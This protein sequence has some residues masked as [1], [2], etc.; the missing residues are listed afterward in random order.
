MPFMPP[1]WMT[2]LKRDLVFSHPGQAHP[3]QPLHAFHG[4]TKHMHGI[5]MHTSFSTGAGHSSEDLRDLPITR[6]R[7]RDPLV[8][9]FF[10]EQAVHEFHAPTVAV[11]GHL[12]RLQTWLR[13]VSLGGGLPPQ[14][15]ATRTVRTRY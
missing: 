1:P 8:P 13:Y 7:V 14:L 6:L 10:A 3:G 4:P 11:H 12:A 9:H 2:F 15:A 5:A